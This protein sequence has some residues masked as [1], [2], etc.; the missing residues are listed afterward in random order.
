MLRW[1]WETLLWPRRDV[2]ATSPTGPT[3]LEQFLELR[4][5][6]NALEVD[7]KKLLGRITGWLAQLDGPEDEDE[8]EE[9]EE[10]LD[11]H[12]LGAARRFGKA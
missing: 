8:D 3:L 1:L 4:T 10:E 11:E 6:V 9:E 12:A 7:Y 5:R 2:P